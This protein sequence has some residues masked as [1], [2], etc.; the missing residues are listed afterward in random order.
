MWIGTDD[1]F[2]LWSKGNI[3]P[4]KLTPSSM[5]HLQILSMLE[6][7]DGNLWLGT[8]RGLLRYNAL[9]AEWLEQNAELNGAAVTALMQDGEGDIWFGNGTTLERLQRTPMLQVA[10]TGRYAW[11]AVY[12][13]VHGRTWLARMDGGLYWMDRVFFMPLGSRAS[14]KR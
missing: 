13:D 10:G 5:Q 7:R 14:T 9:G 11:G 1:G 12:N 8:S 2:A 4:Q 3:T 6:D